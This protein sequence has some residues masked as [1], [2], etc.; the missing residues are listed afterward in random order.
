MFKFESNFDEFGETLE[1]LQK[2][3]GSLDGQQMSLA[4]LFDPPFMLA[5]T[6]FNTIDELFE[7]G[8]FRI[9]STEDLER[10]P[11]EELDRH[12]AAHTEFATW[13]DM[14]AAAGQ[15]WAKRTLGL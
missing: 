7:A 12:V 15:E 2:K 5:Y 4:E 8:G 6:Q 3:A 9:E 14:F 10:L 1:K 11:E 13:S